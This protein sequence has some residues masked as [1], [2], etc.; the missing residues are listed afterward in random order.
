MGAGDPGNTNEDD[1][2]SGLYLPELATDA[3]RR[4]ALGLLPRVPGWPEDVLLQIRQES[5]DGSVMGQVG[6]A[7]AATTRTLVQSNLGWRAYNGQ[8]APL[9]PMAEGPEGFYEALLNS[10]L[11]RRARPA[12]VARERQGRR[13]LR[14]RPDWQGPG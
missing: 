13:Y 6:N 7:S 11:P 10:L 3:T 12:A 2:L 14:N 4:I 9:G 5:L 1:A 8:G